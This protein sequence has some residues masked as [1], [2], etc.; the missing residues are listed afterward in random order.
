ML[1]S[2]RRPQECKKYALYS[3]SG[4]LAMRHLDVLYHAHST[5]NLA[6]RLPALEKAGDT[7][8]ATTSSLTL[9]N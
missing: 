5:H 6:A 4:E 2:A 8:S 9:S 1:V 7:T 3:S